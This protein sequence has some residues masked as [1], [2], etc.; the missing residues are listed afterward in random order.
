MQGPSHLPIP[1]GGAGVHGWGASL[2]WAGGG[3]HPAAPRPVTDGPRLSTV[4]PLLAGTWWGPVWRCA[5]V[6]LRGRCLVPVAGPL[7]C[8]GLGSSVGEG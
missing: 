4:P 7:G 3:L 6:H 8:W 5:G 1:H 2:G